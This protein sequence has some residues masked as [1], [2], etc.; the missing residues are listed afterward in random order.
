MYDNKE[1]MDYEASKQYLFERS[2]KRA[3]AITFFSTLLTLI[4]AGAL[5]ALMPL[6]TSVPFIVKV[7]KTT[8]VAEV[9]TVLNKK[10]LTT[11]EAIDKHFINLYTYIRE[12]YYFDTLEKDYVFVQQLSND[13]VSSEYKKIYSGK[14]ARHDVNKDNVIEKVK[15]LSTVPDVSAGRRMARVRLEVQ[16]ISKSTKSIIKTK[17]LLITLSYKYYPE[18]ELSEDERLVNPLG[19]KVLSY[20]VDTE[21]I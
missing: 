11:N 2:N 7:D 12:G 1:A 9:I 10:K 18:A 5:F 4:L 15:L 16:V 8:G 17:H 6:K 19:F 21:V 3:W 20:R 14:Y 13:F